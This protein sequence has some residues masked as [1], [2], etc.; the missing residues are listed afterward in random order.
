MNENLAGRRKGGGISAF[1]YPPHCVRSENRSTA[2]HVFED[3]R[4]VAMAGK[5]WLPL[6]SSSFPAGCSI[7]DCSIFE[8]THAEG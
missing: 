2:G 3:T 4:C 5:L 6:C 7:A 1:G 8:Y